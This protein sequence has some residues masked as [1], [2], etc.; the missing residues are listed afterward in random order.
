MINVMAQVADPNFVHGTAVLV[1]VCSLIL[2]AGGS[3]VI[4]QKLILNARKLRREDVPQKTQEV[5]PA[6]TLAACSLIHKQLEANRAEFK[7]EHEKQHE[8]LQRSDDAQ[9]LTIN[10]HTKEMGEMR[11]M[12]GDIPQ[13]TADLIVKIR[14]MS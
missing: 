6:Q 2:T 4:V 5:D 3:V 7:G 11:T 14:S 8:G 12:I 9:W 1:G 13:K 10:Q